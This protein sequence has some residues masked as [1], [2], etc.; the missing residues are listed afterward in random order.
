MVR[1]AECDRAR[2]NFSRFSVEL[3]VCFIQINILSAAAEFEPETG[4]VRG[5]S[6]D[7]RGRHLD[8]DVSSRQ[9]ELGSQR[10]S[11]VFLSR[12]TTRD[13]QGGLLTGFGLRDARATV[14][15]D[16]KTR[17]RT[18]SPFRTDEV[19]VEVI[20]VRRKLNRESARTSAGGRPA[21]RVDARNFIRVGSGRRRSPGVS[22][23]RSR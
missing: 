13:G 18:V 6:R 3:S 15:G 10:I 19:I 11:A 16:R 14:R 7:R 5:S 9:V 20:G 21:R 23:S 12:Q 22:L 17:D 4:S 2:R 1:S 8:L